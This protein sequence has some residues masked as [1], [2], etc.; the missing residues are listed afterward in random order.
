[1]LLTEVTLIAFATAT[2]ASPANLLRRDLATVQAAF[3]SI[4]ASVNTFDAGVKSVTP[5]TVNSLS[6]MSGNVVNALNAGIA[7]VTPTSP[8][9]LSDSIGLLGSSNTLVSAVNTTINDLVGK[10]FIIDAANADAVVVQQLQTQKSAS[11]AFIAVVIS[12]VPSTVASLAN[13]QAQQVVA[14]LNRGITAFGGSA[15]WRRK[16]TPQGSGNLV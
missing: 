12:K 1:M 2:I 8:L 14:A 5:Q 13:Q 6:A 3:S 4:S 15:T 7:S 11:Q 16:L 10:K 9:S